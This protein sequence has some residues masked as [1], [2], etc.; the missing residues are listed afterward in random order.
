MR[1]V[2]T[3]GYTETFSRDVRPEAF[4]SDSDEAFP[5]KRDCGV[6]DAP[7]AARG[8]IPLASGG[9]NAPWICCVL[10]VVDVFRYVSTSGVIRTGIWQLS[11]I[12]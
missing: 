2:I 12:R 7:M 11:V 6:S 3:P 5:G 9:G 1:A 10:P 8:T 4:S